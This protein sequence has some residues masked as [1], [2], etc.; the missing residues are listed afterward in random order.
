KDGAEGAT[1]VKG[2]FTFTLSNAS[3]TAT[4]VN[5][6]V[7]G[8]AT[9]GTDYTSLGTSVVIPA[10]TKVFTVPVD[11]QDDLIAEGTETVTLT[12]G[13][14]S[15]TAIT[16]SGPAATV[17]ITDNDAVTVVLSGAATVNENAGTVT[18]TATLTGATGSSIQNAVSVISAVTAGSAVSPADYTTAGTGTLTFAAGSSVGSTKTFTVTVI[19]DNLVEGD[20]TY[21]ASIGSITGVATLG[22]SSI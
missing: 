18:Y 17:N 8:T 14:T 2:E 1:P 20:E 9:S 19:D 11:V 5:F 6:T 7:T 16:V 12:L 13:S 10:G 15:N 21:T 4:T 22:T 3:S